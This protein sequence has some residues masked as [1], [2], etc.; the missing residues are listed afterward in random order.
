MTSRNAKDAGRG[1]GVV[2]DLYTFTAEVG[3]CRDMTG[4]ENKEE[5]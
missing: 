4:D 5:R 1:R 2:S 3:V